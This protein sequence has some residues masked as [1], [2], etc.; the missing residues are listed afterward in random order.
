ML[1]I[2]CARIRTMRIKCFCY[3]VMTVTLCILGDAR[4]DKTAPLL[5]VFSSISRSPSKPPL[6][7]V[8]LPCPV[9]RAWIWSTP[10]LPQRVTLLSAPVV[11]TSSTSR[12]RRPR[13][14]RAALL[15][16]KAPRRLAWRR[17]RSSL[18]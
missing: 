12:T 5:P 11:V 9:A 2:D 1:P 18:A 16:R 3:V 14:A 10:S 13:T 8:K 6:S 17:E 15:A 4:A 7:S